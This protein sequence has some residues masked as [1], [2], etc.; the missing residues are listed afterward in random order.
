MNNN[1]FKEIQENKEPSKE[2]RGRILGNVDKI[3]LAV[4]LADLFL[5][6]QPQ[7]ITTLFEKNKK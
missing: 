4:D 7:I 1:P 5:I 3:Q 2:L 6:K